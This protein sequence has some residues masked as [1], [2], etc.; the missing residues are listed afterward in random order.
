MIYQASS[1]ALLTLMFFFY[2][3]CYICMLR[4]EPGESWKSRRTLPPH[5]IHTCCNVHSNNSNQYPI[6]SQL[7]LMWLAAWSLPKSPPVTNSE[8][9]KFEIKAFKACSV[10]YWVH[11]TCVVPASCRGTRRPFCTP[12]SVQKG[13]NVRRQP[14]PPAL[15]PAQENLSSMT[16]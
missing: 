7:W 14:C 12:S 5:D 15:P 6:I 16:I 4:D 8:A 13:L 3:A 1:C 2:N 10:W 9:Q 11:Y